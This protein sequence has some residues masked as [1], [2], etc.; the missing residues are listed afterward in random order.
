MSAEGSTKIGLHKNNNSANCSVT[1]LQHG[2]L[3]NKL[4]SSPECSILLRRTW[5]HWRVM[6][7]CL[8]SFHSTCHL[9]HS[10]PWYV[11]ASRA[12]KWPVAVSNPSHL[13]LQ[14]ASVLVCSTYTSAGLA[15]KPNT[16]SWIVIWLERTHQFLSPSSNTLQ[17]PET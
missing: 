9:C 14:K 17:E 6:I 2:I 12:L 4:K 15:T 13:H 8:H 7:E 11:A 5:E 1:K 10:S 3:R 16:W